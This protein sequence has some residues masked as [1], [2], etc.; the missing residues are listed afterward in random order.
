MLKKANFDLN[1]R[2][3]AAKIRIA[4][5]SNKTPVSEQTIRDLLPNLQDTVELKQN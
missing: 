2:G 1:E 4:T 3:I 5:E